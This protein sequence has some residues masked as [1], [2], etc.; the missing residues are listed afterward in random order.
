MLRPLI[1]LACTD[2]APG[3]PA[4]LALHSCWRIMEYFHPLE[5]TRGSFKLV[6]LLADKILVVFG[7]FV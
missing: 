1:P 7:L 5:N 6:Y 3:G 4:G 2:I